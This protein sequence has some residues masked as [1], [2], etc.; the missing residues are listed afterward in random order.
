MKNTEFKKIRRAMEKV[1]D[2][3]RYEHTLGVTYTAGCLAMYYGFDIQTAELAG[4]LHD[5]AKCME[6]SKKIQICE[7]H[8]I[9][10]DP[11]ERNHPTLLHAKVGSFIAMDTYGVT[12]KDIINAIL[13]HTT[14][15]PNMSFLEKI[16]FVADY[17]EPSRK[18]APN[19]A[20]IRRAA[21]G[22][23]DDALLTILRD[24]LTYLKA[25]GGDILP[26][27]QKAYEYYSLKKA[28]NIRKD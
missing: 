17:I 1:L 23:L 12:D 6:H 20:E 19:L 14:G 5:C 13:N 9:S 10:I 27:T 22:N 8:N 15:R 2:D 25:G 7:K 11:I 24:T 16:I 3:K 18:D 28:D 4:L 21:F 26:L